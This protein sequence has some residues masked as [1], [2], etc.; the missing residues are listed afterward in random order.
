EEVAAAVRAF[1]GVTDC[2]VMA[3]AEDRG[4]GSRIAVLAAGNIAS[5]EELKHFLAGRLESQAL[6][7]ILRITDCIPTKNN[8]KYDRET[9]L[10]LLGAYSSAG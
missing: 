2:L 3:L 4:R 6:P 1:P 10:R 8:G 5:P 9:A 7:K